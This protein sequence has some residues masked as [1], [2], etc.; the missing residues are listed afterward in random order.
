MASTDVL[1]PLRMTGTAALGSYRMMPRLGRHRKQDR[2]QRRNRSSLRLCHDVREADTVDL[3]LAA[4]VC[5]MLMTAWYRSNGG[6][7]HRGVS[8]LSLGVPPPDL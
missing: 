2:L 7:R 8:I 5:L 1:D 4:S 3:D 6:A